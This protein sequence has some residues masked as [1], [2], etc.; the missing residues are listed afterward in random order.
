MKR[1]RIKRL[2]LAVYLASLGVL[3]FSPQMTSSQ[4][5]PAQT[6]RDSCIPPNRNYF[7]V[8][9][10]DIEITDFLKL[11]AQLAKKNVLVDETIK[12]KI[13]ILSHSP[14][15][16]SR[17]VDFMKQ[18]LE[19]RG[20]TVLEEPNLV[21]IV[22]MDVANNASIPDAHR[23]TE[24]DTNLTS[25]VLR[26]PPS[27]N[28]NDLANVLKS[29]GGKNTVVAP[30]KPAN[31]III[32]GYAPNVR[33][34]LALANELIPKLDA[35]GRVSVETDTVHIY[36]VKNMPAEGLAQT[37]TRLDNPVAPAPATTTPAVPGQPVVPVP[38]DTTPKPAG[39]IRAVSHKESNSLIVT[40]SDAEWREI[41][42]IINELDQFRQQILLEVLIA[43][44][45]S[46]SLND[47]GIDWRYKGSTSGVA[48]PYTQFN[49]GL[50][51]EGKI[52]DPTSGQITNNNTLSG[53]S[54]GFLKS[55]GQLLAIFNANMKNQ[56]FNVLSAPQVLTLDNQEAEINV[57]QDVPVRTQERT[58][59]GGNA[60]ATV[61]SFE[62]RPSG[63]KLKFT[64]HVN[65]E[66]MISIDLFSEVTTIEGANSSITN[67]TF[68]KRNVKTYITV[69]NKQTIVIGGL[70]GSQKQETIFKIPILGDIPLIGFIFRRTTLSD[71]STNLMVFITPHILA[72]KSEADRLS[73]YKREE[74]IRAYRERHNEI[75]LWPQRE[76]P[77]GRDE[78]L[79]KAEKE[80]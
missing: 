11:M 6:T 55:G 73:N 16:V 65:P 38:V 66:G 4:T 68:N 2:R 18:V 40:A 80:E 57:G 62:Y 29:L 23:L 43:E 35:T 51:V 15:P 34:V 41:E 79:D 42:Q 5:P 14:I 77:V 54:L 9:Y 10:R 69:G 30:Y 78:E 67:P 63:I 21:K 47:F 56:N 33:R 20:L 76:V 3:V 46:S 58:S 36:R 25:Q 61:N 13:T 39:K 49:S 28:I 52:I 37:L 48:A 72:D 50:A 1:G 17:A 32:T 53:F 22:P 64:H 19:L 8:S 12:G 24:T 26:V 74:Q 7:C 31:T 45:T 75:K 44:V 27:V 71:Q 59:G 70:V 60:E